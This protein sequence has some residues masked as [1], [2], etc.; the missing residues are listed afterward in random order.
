MWLTTGRSWTLARHQ[1]STRGVATVRRDVTDEDLQQL[2]DAGVH[3]VRYNFVKRL[4]DFTPKAD[5]E[6]IASRVA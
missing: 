2:H 5:I 6:E 3:G 4:A 1:T